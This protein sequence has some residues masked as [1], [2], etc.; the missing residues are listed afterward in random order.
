MVNVQLGVSLVFVVDALHF[1]Q[2]VEES[3]DERRTEKLAGSDRTT[4]Y[5]FKKSWRMVTSRTFW[6]SG[7]K[8]RIL[9]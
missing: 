9:I 2:V 1:V 4:A 3:D 5:F 6:L 8:T 7:S